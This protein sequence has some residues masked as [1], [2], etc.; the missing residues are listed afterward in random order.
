M[1]SRQKRYRTCYPGN[2]NWSSREFEFAPDRELNQA[3]KGFDKLVTIRFGAR[4]R[5]GAIRGRK[6]MSTGLIAGVAR[7]SG[8]STCYL[9][10]AGHE[11]GKIQPR[12]RLAG[13]DRNRTG[14]ETYGKWP[15][16]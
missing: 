3:A 8:L 14:G 1:P 12:I 9:H 15:M 16:G 13:S 4:S 6:S 11:A 7:P 10:P 5:D 2:S